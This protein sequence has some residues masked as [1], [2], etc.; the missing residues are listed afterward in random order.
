MIYF[1]LVLVIF[2]SLVWFVMTHVNWRSRKKI[3]HGI[4]ALVPFLSSFRAHPPGPCSTPWHPGDEVHGL[5]Q[6]SNTELLI[7][8]PY[9]VLISAMEFSSFRQIEERRRFI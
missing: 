7:G 3:V 6:P 1:L 5:V 2:N 9:L 4:Q 8:R